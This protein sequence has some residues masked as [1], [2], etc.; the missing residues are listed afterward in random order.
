M[1]QINFDE[2]LNYLESV[3]K[4]AFYL[5]Y[6][7]AEAE[8]LAQE[9]FLKAYTNWD[10]YEPGTNCKAWLATIMRNTHINRVKK[11]SHEP[12]AIPPEKLESFKVELKESPVDLK[13]IINEMVSDEIKAAIL[14]LP[15]EFIET[16]T[17]AWL[18]EFS[19]EDIARIMECP[20]GTVMSRL[21][22][23]RLF[24]RKNLEEYCNRKA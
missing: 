6:N 1:Q 2:A 17:L 21:A 8:D 3:Y 13:K 14:K 23:A 19:Y 7:Q 18:G 24:L 4:M 12:Q 16:L 15:D 11:E 5:T 22:R 10:K 20:I 9:T